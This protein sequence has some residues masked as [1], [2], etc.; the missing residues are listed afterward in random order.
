MSDRDDEKRLVF[1]AATEDDPA[2]EQFL[3]LGSGLAPDRPLP[4]FT[5]RSAASCRA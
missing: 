4:F 5:A 2:S 3:D 1:V